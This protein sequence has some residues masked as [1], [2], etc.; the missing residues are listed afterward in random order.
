MYF[1]DPYNID[2]DGAKGNVV[3][4]QPTIG[5]IVLIGEKK[6]YQTLN[7]FV[8]NTTQYRL[9]LWEA[10]PRIDWNELSDFELF[11]MLYSSIDKDAAKLIFGDLDFSKFVL[12]GKQVS[13]DTVSPILYNEESDI[14]INEDV[15][16]HFC[17]YLRNVFNVFP[18]E[19]LTS[20][21]IMKSW[22]IKKDQRQL[23]I[24]KEKE[25]KQENSI[26]SI[27]SA[28][29][30]HPGFKYDL[31]GLRD[32]PVFQFYD[33]V[34]RLQVYES[35]RALMSGMYSGFVDASHID[36]NNYN[37]MRDV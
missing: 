20:D 7:I 22:F 18:E 27:I 24:D 30:N 21:P 29:I 13:E 3:V 36:A 8:T 11:L 1:G 9:P 31:K 17:Q 5:D 19:K 15:Y 2:L 12:C 23:A 34:K 25:V 33:S 32:V 26:Q 35:S 14:E 4:Y 10:K 16:N 37:F 28:C 6:F